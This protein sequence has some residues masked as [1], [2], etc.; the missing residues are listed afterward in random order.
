MS[1]KAHES[2][3]QLRLTSAILVDDWGG[4]LFLVELHVYHEM[5]LL[6]RESDVDP[7]KVCFGRAL[8]LRLWQRKGW[9]T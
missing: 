1:N 5:D 8:P 9:P 3:S 2:H 6:I 7:Q 4:I